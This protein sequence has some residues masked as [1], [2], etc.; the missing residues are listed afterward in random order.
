MSY[1]LSIAADV[2]NLMQEG[3][4]AVGLHKF[5]STGSAVVGFQCCCLSSY[6]LGSVAAM[7]QVLPGCTCPAQMTFFLICHEAGLTTETSHSY[8]FDSAEVCVCLSANNFGR[9]LWLSQSYSTNMDHFM[10]DI[11]FL[12]MSY[13]QVFEANSTV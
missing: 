11:H 13:D 10:S 4:K 3:R 12:Q 6:C 9:L 2:S 8:F 7:P 1:T 5:I